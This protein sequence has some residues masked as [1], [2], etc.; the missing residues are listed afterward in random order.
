M[1]SVNATLARVG[2][3]S[4]DGRLVVAVAVTVADRS[5]IPGRCN[6]TS[7]A[8][9][10]SDEL[11]S[12]GMLLVVL[13]ALPVALT[14]PATLFA[15]PEL[16]ARL[17]I[18][19]G[20][21][22]VG[23]RL[24]Q[25]GARQSLRLCVCLG[26]RTGGG[27]PRGG[28]LHGAALEGLLDGAQRRV[29]MEDV[30]RSCLVTGRLQR[31]GLLSGTLADAFHQLHRDGRCALEQRARANGRLWSIGQTPMTAGLGH[32]GGERDPF[33]LMLRVNPALENLCCCRP[34]SLIFGQ[35]LFDES[36]IVRWNAMTLVDRRHGLAKSGLILIA[37]RFSLRE[38]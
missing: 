5:R 34:F 38:R 18:G 8:P 35:H 2:M 32:T 33:H 14:G 19:R 31:L 30:L 24:H 12:G 10:H 36:L 23:M 4:R 16:V 6:L 1:A 3:R 9:C 22:L 26:L 20:A 25:L 28:D 21:L 37:S 17:Q 7:G 27:G 11:T 29:A 15:R 13:A